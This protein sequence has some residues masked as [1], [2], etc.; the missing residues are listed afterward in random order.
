MKRNESGECSTK[1]FCD[2]PLHA[3]TTIDEHHDTLLNKIKIAEP[4][5]DGCESE[6][7]R[8]KKSWLEETNS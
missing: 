4:T 1:Q 5:A 2:L 6:Q 3:S 8:E 7:K